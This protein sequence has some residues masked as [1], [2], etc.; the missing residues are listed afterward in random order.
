MT[1]RSSLINERRAVI[2]RPYSSK[3]FNLR[4]LIFE[5]PVRNEPNFPRS[6]IKFREIAPASQHAQRRGLPSLQL[7]VGNRGIACVEHALEIHDSRDVLRSQPGRA[8]ILPQ[9]E[10]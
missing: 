5:Q 3:P 8:R 7:D 10:R 4:L 2:D 9:V 1:A 6:S